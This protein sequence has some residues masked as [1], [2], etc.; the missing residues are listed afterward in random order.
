M[1]GVYL[2]VRATRDDVVDLLSTHRLELGADV[3]SETPAGWSALVL[4]DDALEPVL[5]RLMAQALGAT[6]A[7]L[8]NS[9]ER[10]L[11]VRALDDVTRSGGEGAAADLG[12][13]AA[14]LEAVSGRSLPD[15]ALERGLHE[16]HPGISLVADLSRH[17]GLPHPA[18]A[19]DREVVAYR[20]PR[21]HVRIWARVARPVLLA[22]A[23]GGW[24][25]VVPYPPDFAVGEVLG[26]FLIESQLAMAKD[27]ALVVGRREEERWVVLVTGPTAAVPVTVRWHWQPTRLRLRE[28][29]PDARP[30][31]LALVRAFPGASAATVEEALVSDADPGLR[32]LLAALDV[33]GEV[34]EAL[35]MP[36]EELVAQAEGIGPG[37]WRE[38]AVD[39]VTTR[40]EEK[41]LA[42]HPRLARFMEATEPG[43]PAHR[44]S[45]RALGLT[46]SVLGAIMVLLALVLLAVGVSLEGDGLLP[47]EPL[48]LLL[49]GAALVYVG[50]QQHRRGGG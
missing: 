13:L 19:P 22:P 33:P 28:P 35:E 30:V 43:G 44:W 14:A 39:F 45:D 36:L 20:G 10:E 8:T 4:G 47:R 2:A 37:P 1:D 12:E 46:M 21:E 18:P 31:A 41:Y 29:D 7:V 11:V 5:G 3:L 40:T 25:L 15:E 26:E 23:V 49:V 27:R 42:D 38:L 24:E 9:E 48:P 32:Q 17:L 6:V 34:V 50:R 16:A